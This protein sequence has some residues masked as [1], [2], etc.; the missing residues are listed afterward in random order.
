MTLPNPHELFGLDEVRIYN[1]RFLPFQDRVMAPDGNIYYPPGDEKYS[2]D[3]SQLGFGAQST[4]IH[5]LRHVEQHQKGDFVLAIGAFE[6][7]LNIL[8]FDQYTYRTSELKYGL[9]QLSQ[10]QEAAI[11]Q[12]K[13]LENNG[14]VNDFGGG[15]YFE[16]PDAKFGLGKFGFNYSAYS[17]DLLNGVKEGRYDVGDLI[18][19]SATVKDATGQ[20]IGHI[21]DDGRPIATYDTIGEFA[22]YLFPVALD[23]DGDGLIKRTDTSVYS[24]MFD[25]DGDGF[26]ENS[27]W[28]E[29]DDGFL[30]D[31][32]D[33]N[34]ALV[35]ESGQTTHEELVFSARTDAADTDLEAFASLHDTNRDGVVDANDDYFSRLKVWVDNIERNGKVDAG[36]M[37]TLSELGITSINVGTDWRTVENLTQNEL[38]AWDS[39]N[40]PSVQIVEGANGAESAKQAVVLKEG[41]TLFGVSSFSKNGQNYAVADIAL[42]TSSQG[43]RVADDGSGQ[44][45]FQIE[46]AG[47]NVESAIRIV[48]EGQGA[49]NINLATEQVVGAIG[50]DGNDT[51]NASGYTDGTSV[52]LDGGAGVDT[53]TGGSGDDWLSGGADADNIS[54]GDGDDTIFT[55]G[56][57]TLSGG[58]GYDIAITTGTD[59]QLSLNLGSTGIEAAVGGD[60]A[61]TLNGSTASEGV[62]LS[63]Q[64]GN[65]TLTGSAQADTLSG[66]E[67]ADTLRAGAGDDVVIVDKA[68]LDS[69]VVVGGDGEDTMIVSDTEA[70]TINMANYDFEIV[71][72]GDGGDTITGTSGNDVID[73]GAG[74]DKLTGGGGHDVL[75]IDEADKTRGEINAGDGRDAIVIDE[76]GGMNIDLKAYNA[77]I[78]IG[79][80]GNDQIDA[81][82]V[83]TWTNSYQ[84]ERQRWVEI[85]DQGHGYWE[86]YY[87]TVTDSGSG[88]RLEGKAGDDTLTG[89][90]YV[91]ELYG[92]DGNDAL[93]GGGSNDTLDGGDGNDKLDGGSGDNR[94][95]FQRGD[96][97]DTILAQSGGIHRLYFEESVSIND[98]WLQRLDDNGNLSSSGDD[99][100]IL[101]LGE[102]QSVTIKD[103]FST[104]ATVADFDIRAAGGL[105]RLVE[106]TIASLVPA[107]AAVTQPTGGN[108]SPYII[109]DTVFISVENDLNA[110]WISSSFYGDQQL[111]NGDDGVQNWNPTDDKDDETLKSYGG[112]DIINAKDGE[113]LILGGSGDDDI[114][115]GSQQD[116]IFGGTGDDTIDGGSNSDIIH[117]DQGN[118]TISGG[119]ESD[120]LYGGDGNDTLYGNAGND[121]LNGGGGDDTLYG[122][123]GDDTYIFQGQFGDDRVIEDATG[124]DTVIFEDATRNDIRIYRSVLSNETSDGTYTT[125]DIQYSRDL[126]IVVDNAGWVRI[127]DYFADTLSNEFNPLG[128]VENIA[129]DGGSTTAQLIKDTLDELGSGTILE[130]KVDGDDASLGKAEIDHIIK[131]TDSDD[132]LTGTSERD[133]LIGTDG[134]DVL[135]GGEGN[136]VLRGGAGDDDYIFTGQF[137]DDIVIDEQGGGGNWDMVKFA[138][139]TPD[140]IEFYRQGLDLRITVAGQGSVVIRNHFASTDSAA[141]DGESGIEKFEYAG[142]WTRD[143]RLQEAFNTYGLDARLTPSGT[144]D[145]VTLDE[146][147]V[148]AP[149]TGT[150]DGDEGTGSGTSSGLG[151][152]TLN[153]MTGTAG[154]DT[155]TSTSADDRL[156]GGA[157]SDYYVFQGD[158][159]NDEVVDESGG[160][161]RL[162]FVGF[163]KEDLRFAKSGRDLVVTADDGAG[164]G[165]TVTVKDHYVDGAIGSTRQIGP[166]PKTARCWSMNAVIS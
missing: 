133:E 44:L 77:E 86:T 67:G 134:D 48:E 5:E 64:G 59:A 108:G 66:G 149:E 76:V 88:T 18:G 93:H 37:K 65:D 145:N 114:D 63:G 51:L 56:T 58:A 17:S 80:V 111:H 52:L 103:Y 47:G 84:V 53:L 121:A 30:I 92:G 147:V 135:N 142:G 73:G 70:V 90:A 143:S 3:I 14:F 50:A 104:S 62:Y 10:E 57:D 81:S 46:G 60:L 78:G 39:S 87:E 157:G 15:Y 19:G 32:I 148:S 131:G 141:P 31:D 54:G 144:G 132:Q 13:F 101:V 11:E 75:V 124:L 20:I 97:H 126:F 151:T 165:G 82:N 68:D 23:L 41:N 146:V 160:W 95:D 12:D 110:A 138:D 8:G 140:K 106:P 99:L 122:G 69:G 6:Q 115:G 109:D 91:D 49:T 102:D 166:T 83:T 4:F 128:V 43:Y 79:G 119:S 29:G 153:E 1:E 24:R 136:D 9:N 42:V 116:L 127:K 113:D 162:K 16:K 129:F 55:D 71:V 163:A 125:Q 89:S 61:D 107:M 25:S 94:Y 96:G 161:D 2:D 40:S 150:G 105:V 154:D 159:G 156:I 35:D 158:F 38:N 120:R 72:G 152:T 98:I 22:E 36:E 130:I 7:I 155:L 21:N 34:G 100:K 112:D 123:A 137:G 45:E 26:V 118:D 164:N 117:G 28:L 85:N 74:G 139:A 27:G 33:G